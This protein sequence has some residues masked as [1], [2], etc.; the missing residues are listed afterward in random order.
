MSSVN[1]EINRLGK[2]TD[3]GNQS[4]IFYLLKA[5]IAA[6]LENQEK[7]SET[8]SDPMSKNWIDAAFNADKLA[9]SNPDEALKLGLTLCLLPDN[10][11]KEKIYQW[12]R[13]DGPIILTNDKLKKQLLSYLKSDPRAAQFVSRIEEYMKFDISKF[14]K[15][16]MF[17]EAKCFLVVSSIYFGIKLGASNEDSASNSLYEDAVGLMAK[18]EI[19]EKIKYYKE[20]SDTAWIVE[21]LEPFLN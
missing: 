17:N 2:I 5:R 21:E 7:G 14:S 3:R 13:G 9:E 18:P 1:K 12:M 11:E 15:E 20:S 19:S 6:G 8:I 10:T 16:Q 4:K